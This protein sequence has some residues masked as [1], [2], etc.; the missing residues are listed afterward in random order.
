MVAG[1]SRLIGGAS[2]ATTDGSV[3]FPGQFSVVAGASAV[4]AD[5]PSLRT[6][7]KILSGN[8]SEYNSD[9]IDYN[10]PPHICYHI[11]GEVLP[12]EALRLTPPHQSPRSHVT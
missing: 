2:G 8:D 5:F 6:F 3:C 1:A 9:N 12:K 4:G 10:T 7:L 11:N